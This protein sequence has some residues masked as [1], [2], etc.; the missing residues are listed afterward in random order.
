ML[1]KYFFF[2]VG[3]RENYMPKECHKSNVWMLSMYKSVFFKFINDSK[4][5]F[6]GL[7]V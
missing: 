2:Y 1:I 6:E 3:Q 5:S 4:V 7:L